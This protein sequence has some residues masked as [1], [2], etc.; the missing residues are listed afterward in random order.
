M[1]ARATRCGSSIPTYPAYQRAM[2][3]SHHSAPRVAARRDAP[4][5]RTQAQTENAIATVAASDSRR[6]T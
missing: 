6:P 1:R 2:E 5:R 4:N 3:A